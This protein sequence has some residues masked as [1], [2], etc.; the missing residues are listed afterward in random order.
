MLATDELA[1]DIKERGLSQPIV[2]DSDGRT[3]RAERERR[4]IGCLVVRRRRVHCFRSGIKPPGPP[5]PPGSRQHV[6]IK[7][8]QPLHMARQRRRIARQ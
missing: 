7:R 2:L 1:A 6:A 4:L 3:R 8:G 5:P